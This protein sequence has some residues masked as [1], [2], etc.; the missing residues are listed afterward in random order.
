MGDF[1]WHGCVIPG[2]L[3]YDTELNVWVRMLGDLAEL[4]MTDVAQTMAGRIVQVSWKKAGRSY[5]R[6]RSVAVVESAKWVGPFPTPLSG[7]LVAV[8]QAGFTADPAVANSDPYGA[9]WLARMRP[10]ALAAEQHYLSDA[11]VAFAAYRA[12]IDERGI[13]CMRCVGDAA[14]SPTRQDEQ[15]RRPGSPDRRDP[16]EDPS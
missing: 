11:A 7:E 13:S 4:G 9:G 5:A 16:R 10:S 15:D 3:L 14:D 6:G 12:L 1:R 8:N 2:D